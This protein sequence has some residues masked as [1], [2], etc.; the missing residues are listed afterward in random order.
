MGIKRLIYPLL[1]AVLF[2]SVG[3]VASVETFN[4]QVLDAR[5]KLKD[6]ALVSCLIAIDPDSKLG[7]DLKYSKRSLSFMG[8]GEYMIVQNEETL[9]TEHDPYAEAVSVLVGEAKQSRGYMKN[10]EISE[11]YGC[12]NAYQSKKFNE[13]IAGQDAFITAK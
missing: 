2:F 10:G 13:F 9:E 1:F 4:K 7:K 12:F 8:K 6:Y 11:S 3:C 5:N